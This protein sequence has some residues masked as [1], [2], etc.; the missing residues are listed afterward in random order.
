MFHI[1]VAVA[2]GVSFAVQD[3]GGLGTEHFAGY[4]V[5]KGLSVDNL[6]VFVIMTT[7]AVPEEHKHKVLTVGEREWDRPGSATAGRRQLVGPEQFRTRRR[8]AIFLTSGTQ[9]S[10]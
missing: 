8:L 10:G 1:L 9:R 5:E 2:F 3:G 4:L 6:F 7:F